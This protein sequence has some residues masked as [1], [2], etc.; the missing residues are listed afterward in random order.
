MPILDFSKAF[1]TVSHQRLLYKMSHYGITSNTLQQV[2]AWLT[3]RQQ[4]VY[5]DGES[6]RN[7][8]VKSGVPQGA[9]LGPL[10]F[11]IY[12][13]DMGNSISKKT[14]LRLF[15][16]DSL[17][18]R[19][20]KSTNDIQQLQVDLTTLTK[21]EER[22]QMTFHPAKCYSLRVTRKKT[23]IIE[24][25]EM[26]GHIL[27]TVHQ[28]PYL[29]VELSEDLGWEPHINKAISKANKVLGFLKRNISKCSQDIK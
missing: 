17:L 28:Y 12:I 11:L 27:S 7:N 21:W 5:V 24:N 9:V 15:A 1:D 6:S 20:I 3:K 29:G 25:H 2:S 14:T 16:D 10:R 22:W 8:P 4:R 19:S 23:P 13:N 26:M 18:Y